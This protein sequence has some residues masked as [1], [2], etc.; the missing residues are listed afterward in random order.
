M[1]DDHLRPLAD[2][3]E[4]VGA[5]V[6][7]GKRHT[8]LHDHALIAA[9]AILEIEAIPTTGWIDPGIEVV[10]KQNVK[11][12][13]ARENGTLVVNLSERLSSSG[14]GRCS[15]ATADIIWPG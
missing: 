11:A 8:G 12:V 6:T 5:R 1:V 9:V 4:H 7:L 14:D 2:G 15:I 3:Q 10:T 13:I